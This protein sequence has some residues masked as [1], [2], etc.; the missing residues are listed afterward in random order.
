MDA[1]SP[2][3]FDLPCRNCKYNLRMLPVT[4]RCPECGFPA[5]R[6]YMAHQIDPKRQLPPGVGLPRQSVLLV[7]AKL[8]RRN[9][10][11]VSFVLTAF[12]GRPVPRERV[13]K[14]AR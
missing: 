7:L 8:L 6:S 1:Q 14:S 11:A 4:A 5:L 12:N 3:D 10:D 13:A 9:A 2:I